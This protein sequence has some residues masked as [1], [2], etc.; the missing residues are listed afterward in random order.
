MTKKIVSIADATQ[1]TAENYIARLRTMPAPIFDETMERLT[2]GEDVTAVAKWL[3]GQDRGDLQGA[4][5]QTLRKYLAPLSARIKA[6]KKKTPLIQ[7][8]TLDQQV[9]DHEKKLDNEAAIQGVARP[10]Q[11]D[12][13]KTLNQEIA[14]LVEWM[15]SKTVLAYEFA[16]LQPGIELGRKIEEKMGM[17]LQA[18]LD[19]LRQVHRIG[20]LLDKQEARRPS[21][22]DEPDEAGP[23]TLDGNTGAALTGVKVDIRSMLTDAEKAVLVKAKDTPPPTRL[24]QVEAIDLIT[25]AARERVELDQLEAEIAARKAAETKPPEEPGT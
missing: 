7:S 12:R 2:R 9:R 20:E 24:L 21:D 4:G 15:N 17:P 18:K 25:K 1:R 5:F 3:L 19:L 10:D 11:K 16:N 8:Q 14:G 13:V 6:Q 22:S 23:L